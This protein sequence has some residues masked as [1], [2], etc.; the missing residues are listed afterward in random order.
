M[1]I[2]GVKIG[3]VESNTIIIN[4]PGDGVYHDYSY[5]NTIYY[6]YNKTIPVTQTIIPVGVFDITM[7]YR[8]ETVDS[9][10]YKDNTSDYGH[11]VLYDFDG[12]AMLVYNQAGSYIK[13]INCVSIMFG[14]IGYADVSVTAGDVSKI[15]RFIS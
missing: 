6:I 13:N 11:P 4:N 10:F 14:S 1:V 5:I 3:D 15:I 7:N 9:G 12:D 8:E 2:D